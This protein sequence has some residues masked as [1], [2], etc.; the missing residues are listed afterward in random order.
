M[1]SRKRPDDLLAH[2]SQHVVWKRGEGKWQGGNTGIKFGPSVVRTLDRDTLKSETTV[3]EK[4]REYPQ[5]GGGENRG[6]D[7][8]ALRV[9]CYVRAEKAR[10]VEKEG[11]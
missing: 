10:V 11:V 9:N 1:C 2:L 7:C 4:N 8:A 5:G 6:K 3:R